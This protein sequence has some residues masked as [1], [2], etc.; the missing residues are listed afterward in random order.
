MD[1]SAVLTRPVTIAVLAIGGQGGGVLVDWIVALAE[2]QG[3]L[4]QST[5]VPGV[6]QRTGA[7]IYYVETIAALS[8]QVPVFSAM[9]APGDVDVVIAAEWMEAGRAIQRGLVTPDRTTLIASTHRTYAVSEKEGPGDGTADSGA[10]TRAAAAAARRFVAFDMAALAEQAGSVVSSVLFGALCGSDALPF[11]RAAFEATISAAGI[12]VHGSL[13]GFALGYDAAREPPAARYAVVAAADEGLQPV[14]YAPYD[15]LLAR[16][17][18][19]PASAHAMLAEGLRHVVSFQDVAYGAVYLDAVEAVCRSGRLAM[20]SAADVSPPSWPGLSGPSTTLP[21]A[22]EVVDGR[23]KPGH[24]TWRGADRDSGGDA[25]A[26]TQST[27]T[28]AAAKYI[29][30]AMAYDDVIRVAALKTQ[31]NRAGRVRAEMAAGATPIIA[32]TEFMHPRMDE[33]LG[34][35]PPGL[36]RFLGRRTTLVAWLDKVVCGPKRIRTDTV[37]GFLVLYVVAGLRFWR[38]RT[39]RYAQEWARI[40]SWLSSVRDVAADDPALAVEL[41]TNQR[42]IKGYSETHARGLDKY[43]RVMDAALR[44]RG[45]PDAAAWVRRLR[46]AALKDEAGSALDAALKTVDSFLHERKAA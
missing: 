14:G 11:G 35:L 25:R 17:A 27:L 42:L 34:L 29:A 23:D 15:A 36:G 26:P 33:L 9:A 39:L 12:G 5:S 31:P 3:W 40:D 7:T 13:R 22:R 16:A 41:L 18:A 1:G 45:H 20:S 44:L 8:G 24:D 6:A 37:A 10:V 4:A 2:S 32:T 38:R 46:E 30:R 21:A 19:F 43:A 28:I